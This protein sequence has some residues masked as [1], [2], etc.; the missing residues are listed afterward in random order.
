MGSKNVRQ[1]EAL[2]IEATFGT[3][4]WQWQ[5]VTR[6][7]KMGL[8][9]RRRGLDSP[10]PDAWIVQGSMGMWEFLDHIGRVNQRGRLRNV[11]IK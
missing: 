3:D 7:C 9:S 8:L 4:V 10:L 5:M 6:D 2:I 11:E 1:V